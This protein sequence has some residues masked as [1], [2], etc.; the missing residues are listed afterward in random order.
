MRRLVASLGAL[1][2]IP[3]TVS[4]VGRAAESSHPHAAVAAA[5]AATVAGV[6]LGWVVA[7]VSLALRSLTAPRDRFSGRYPGGGWR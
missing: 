4:S 1:R 5:C 3:L 6:V 2:V 7:Q